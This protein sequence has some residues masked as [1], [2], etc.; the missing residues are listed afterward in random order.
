M[1]KGDFADIKNIGSENSEAGS[2]TAACFLK[3]FVGENKWAHLDIAGVD[4]IES[5]HPYLEKGSTGI[6][7]RLV[8]EAL[9][10]LTKKED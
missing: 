1:I 3:E 4:N 9:L 2:I 7:V 5:S 6:G 8:I 10:H